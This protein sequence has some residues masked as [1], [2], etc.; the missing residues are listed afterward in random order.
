MQAIMAILKEANV[1]VPQAHVLF[2][3]AANEGL[4]MREYAHLT[5]NHQSS[6]SRHLLDMGEINRFHA[7]GL[8]LIEQWTDPMDRRR[9]IYRLTPKGIQ[10]VRKVEEL[11]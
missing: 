4:S 9:N 2:T 8:G 1:S 3:V 10:L 11:I 6:M 7:P 5:D